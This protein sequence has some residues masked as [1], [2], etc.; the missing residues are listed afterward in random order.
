MPAQVSSIPIGLVEPHPKLMLRFKYDVESLADSIRSSVDENTPNGQLNPG[1]V[2]PKK[3]GK[4][5]LVYIG[6]RRYF[7][8]RSLYEKAGEERFATY[9][10]YIDTNTSEVQMF[11]RAKRENDEEKGERKGLSVLEEVFGLGRIRDSISNPAKE[12]GQSLAR[13][14]EIAGVISEER[15]RKLYEIEEA[16]HSRF[17][18]S[19]LEGLAKI[20]DER[21]FCLVASYV[22]ESGI[23]AEK[24]DLAIKGQKAALAFQWFPTVFPDLMASGAGPAS[25]EEP[26]D[27]AERTKDA[28]KG[29]AQNGSVPGLEIHERNVIVIICPEC[30]CENIARVN[31]SVEVTQL[32]VEPGGEG[33]RTTPDTVSRFSCKC[34][35]CDVEFYVFVKHLG[36]N[37]YAVEAL[38]AKTFRE[39]RTVIQAVDLHFDQEGG[40]WQK[41]VGREITGIILRKATGGTR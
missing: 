15:L 38:R 35:A 5:Y 17:G 3:D 12:L 36:G 31:G 23:G 37:Q 18:V 7:A 27:N 40:V 30:G 9:S 25:P 10:A 20:A 22:A 16:T 1:R 11:I 14:L 4:G 32:P 28:G 41:V 26:T 8:L 13:R 2:V 33:Y 34:G 19:Q 39:P 21:E 6:V 29:A 24:M